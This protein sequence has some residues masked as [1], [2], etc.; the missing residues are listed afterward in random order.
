MLAVLALVYNPPV[1]SHPLQQPGEAGV[2]RTRP[3]WQVPFHCLIL[4]HI[5]TNISSRQSCNGSFVW[6]KRTC[7]AHC[8][9]WIGL[10]LGPTSPSCHVTAPQD[11]IGECSSYRELCFPCFKWGQGENSDLKDKQN[12]WSLST[13]FEPGRTLYPRKKK[14][15]R[16]AAVLSLSKPAGWWCWTCKKTNQMETRH[17]RSY[18]HKKNASDKCLEIVHRKSYTRRFWNCI[19]RGL[20][21]IHTFIIY[22]SYLY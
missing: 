9:R 18:K 19:Y 16:G 21:F 3:Q 1:C 5:L 15:C 13:S 4:K 11:G 22:I 12:M 6:E 14:K 17:Q 2:R 7:S 8:T 10:G 20:N